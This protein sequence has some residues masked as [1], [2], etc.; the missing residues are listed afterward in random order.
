MHILAQD[1]HILGQKIHILGEGL[2]APSKTA[3]MI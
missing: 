1:T 3:A 2:F